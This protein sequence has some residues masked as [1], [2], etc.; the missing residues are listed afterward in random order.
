MTSYFMKHSMLRL[1]L[2]LSVSFILFPF[3]LCFAATYYVDATHLQASDSNLGTSENLPWKTISKAAST[4]V[5]GDLVYV[6]KGVYYESSVVFSNSGTGS[7]PIVFQNYP[8]HSPII[9]GSNSGVDKFVHA[10]GKNYIVFDGFDV[11][12]AYQYGIWFDGNNN[13]IRNCIVHDNGRDGGYRNGITLKTEVGGGLNNTIEENRIYNNTWNG[14]SVE[15]CNYTSILHNYVYSNGHQGINVFPR[16]DN[17]TGLESANNIMRNISF[18]NGS[19][20]IY[21][22]YQRDNIISN[23]LVYDNNEWGILLHSGGTGNPGWGN[24]YQANTKVFSNTIV[25]N[26]YDG[27]FIHTGSHVIVENNLF[28]RNNHAPAYPEGDG[29]SNLRVGG[30]EGCIINNNFYVEYPNTTGPFYYNGDMSLS[31]WQAL[32]FDTTVVNEGDPGFVDLS[33][34]DYAL[35]ESSDARDAGAGLSS[36]EI[37]VDIDGIARPQGGKFDIGAYE[38]V[39]KSAPSPPTNLRI[40]Q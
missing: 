16:T 6:K 18:N 32:G 37:A 7:A 25:N 11:R 12:N 4:A 35:T 17:F 30:I 1:L 31:Q 24:C 13:I 38:Y 22:R 40:S 3:A 39:P 8:G 2:V 20:G 27:L 23:N 21:T 34:G 19:S 15:S 14:I 28:Y 5:A 10:R 33:G 26:I 36:E 29:K 9:D